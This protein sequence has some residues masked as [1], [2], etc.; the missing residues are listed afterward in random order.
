MKHHSNEFCMIHMYIE[1]CV[2]V[3]FIIK[4]RCIAIFD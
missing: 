4:E 1:Q 2:A 3:V